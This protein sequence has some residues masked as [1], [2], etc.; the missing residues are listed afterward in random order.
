M[1]DLATYLLDIIQNSISANSSWIHLSIEIHDDLKIAI[2]DNGKGM[3]DEVLKK[4]TSP[5][6]T[7][8]TTRTVGLG[9]SFLKMLCEET[10]GTFAID[11]KE[12]FGTNLYMTLDYLHPDIPPIGNLGELIYTLTIHQD[13]DEFIFDFHYK[14][15]NYHYAC[16]EMKAMFKE[17]LTT[18]SIMQ[19]LIE[20]INQEI[21]IDEVNHEIFRRF[22]ATKR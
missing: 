7:T 4:A 20:F 9:L 8:R 6:F 5:F 16:S 1:D 12:N 17:T 10:N 22:K 15:Y 19:A 18:Y 14:N 13:V 2:K 11:S 21:H 3:T